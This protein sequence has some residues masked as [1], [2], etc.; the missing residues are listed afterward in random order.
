MHITIKSQEENVKPAIM[1]VE[2]EIRTCIILS[3]TPEEA[4]MLARLATSMSVGSV[5]YLAKSR[6]VRAL[7]EVGWNRSDVPVLM[8]KKVNGA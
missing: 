4:E 3:A 2:R 5:L 1:C 7:E 8:Y 6:D